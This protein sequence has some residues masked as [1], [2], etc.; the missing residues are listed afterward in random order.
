MASF[1]NLQKM[2]IVSSVSSVLESTSTSVKVI[3]EEKKGSEE[4]SEENENMIQEEEKHQNEEP[5]NAEQ[6][7]IEDPNLREPTD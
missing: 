3:E 5:Q 6:V 2:S 1:G 4:S 7:L